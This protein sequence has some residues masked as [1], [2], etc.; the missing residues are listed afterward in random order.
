MVFTAGIGEND[1]ELRNEVCKHVAHLGIKLAA[2]PVKIKD[3]VIKL[4]DEDSKVKVLVIP[5]NEELGVA[6]KTYNCKI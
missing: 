6:R 1:A 4:S 5:A 2:K 3:N